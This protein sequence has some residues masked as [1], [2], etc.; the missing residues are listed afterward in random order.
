MHIAASRSPHDATTATAPRSGRR[1][2]LRI[3]PFGP[4]GSVAMLVA[5]LLPA[6]TGAAGLGMEVTYWSLLQIELQRIA[7]AAALSATNAANGGA[8]AQTSANVGADIAELNSISGAAA[9]TW[10]A[11]TNT[12]TDNQ[13]TV[14]KVAGIKDATNAAYQ[15]I[16]QKSVP[17]VITKLITS[18][19]TVTVAATGYAEIV[20]VKVQGC[21]I[22]LGTS[23]NSVHLNNNAAVTQANCA[24]QTNGGITMDNNSTI[25]AGGVSA[26][27]SITMGSGAVINGP[28]QSGA[29]TMT[30]PYAAD[31]NI[32]SAFASLGSGGISGT[33]A[34]MATVT[35]SPG[36]YSGFNF[37]IGATVTLSPG[38]YYVNGAISFSNNVSVTGTG[39]TLVTKGQMA[40]DNNSSLTLSAPTL[41]A[42][43]GIP[44][45]AIAGN[46]VEDWSLSNN[47]TLKVTGVLYYPNGH[48]EANN[49][50]GTSALTCSV[51]VAKTITL[52]NNAYLAN[53]CSASSGVKN[54]PIPVGNPVV[55]L[56]K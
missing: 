19:P 22:A 35:L 41:G 53:N 29:A 14:K 21:V 28:Q 8:N 55:T 39:V 32:A 27:G 16:L 3:G 48:I 45:V 47:S 49:N 51:L 40:F 5:V 18:L 6:M 11:A 24:T 20:P 36:T 9:R 56:V 2:R 42:A 17:L 52:N 25:T 38:T 7:D 13:I 46:S 44:G 4:R 15:V 10:D 31:S 1:P 54:M 12:L 34:S 26:A 50:F 30:D 33:V 23:A 37:G 43:A